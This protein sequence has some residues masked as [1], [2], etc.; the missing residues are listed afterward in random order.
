MKSRYI[1]FFGAGVSGESGMPLGSGLTK[2]WLNHLLPVGVA[3]DIQELFE[4]TSEITGRSC[5]RLELVVGEAVKVFGVECLNLLSFFKHC[6]PNRFHRLIAKYIQEEKAWAFTTNFDKG[7]ET[8]ASIPVHQSGTLGPENWGLVKLHGCIDQPLSS[9][10]VTIEN[11]QQGLPPS[12]AELLKALLQDEGN[13]FVFVGYSGTDY[14]DVVRF[15]MK[16]ELVPHIHQFVRVERKMCGFQR[17]DDL[18]ESQRIVQAHA[19]WIAHGSTATGEEVDLSEGADL[20]LCPFLDERFVKTRGQTYEIAASLL[21]IQPEDENWLRENWKENWESVFTASDDLMRLYAARLFTCFGVGHKVI[22]VLAP[23][24]VTNEEKRLWANALRDSGRYD[25]ERDFRDNNQVWGTTHTEIQRQKAMLSRLR[26]Q[27]WEALARYVVILTRY[28]S[29]ANFRR[30]DDSSQA[31]R[32]VL[33]AGLFFDQMAKKFRHRSWLMA[34]LIF[35]S[36][37]F[38]FLQILALQTF[39]LVESFPESSAPHYQAMFHRLAASLNSWQGRL[40]EFFDILFFDNDL[41]MPEVSTLDQTGAAYLETDSLLGMVNNWRA[42]AETWMDDF[43]WDIA[44]S[45]SP[46]NDAVTYCVNDLEDSLRLA[47]LINDREGVK[48]A[49]ALLDLLSRKVKRRGDWSGE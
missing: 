30:A 26:G 45:F 15:F 47:E 18:H 23:A 24:A 41:P 39:R 8:C 12:Y 25:D 36:Y 17:A 6:P 2:Q 42:S 27:N 33:E 20:M 38:C 48:K 1:F 44:G 5:P 28:K 29:V 40:M 14:F 10:G 13:T 35:I 22:E 32:S 4:K 7:I 16:P 11:I 21:N 34:P 49:N 43:N 37:P 19:I 9:L 3:D 31:I 46:E